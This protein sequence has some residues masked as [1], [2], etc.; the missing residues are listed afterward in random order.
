MYD[1]TLT[2]LNSEALLR[3]GTL[4]TESDMNDLIF[5]GKLASML[6]RTFRGRLTSQCWRLFW[7]ERSLLYSFTTSSKGDLFELV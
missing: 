7:L 1:M 3:E 6:D 2:C 4:F 5:G